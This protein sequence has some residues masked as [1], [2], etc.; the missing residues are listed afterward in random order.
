MEGRLSRAKGR[1]FYSAVEG[2]ACEGL[3]WDGL[4]LFCFK[5]ITL[6]ALRIYRR[7]WGR[8]MQRFKSENVVA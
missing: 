5:R 7:A 3:W 2:R 6:A 8:H 4:I 1:T